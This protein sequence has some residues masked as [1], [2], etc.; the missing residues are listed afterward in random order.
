[1]AGR[2]FGVLRG[3]EISQITSAAGVAAGG[4]A[5]TNYTLLAAAVQGRRYAISFTVSG[6]SGTGDVGIAGATSLWD[7]SPVGSGGTIAGNGACT[8]VG[9]FIASGAINLYT[10]S[11][12]TANFSNISVKEVL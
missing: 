7:V 2:A 3:Q 9:T 4:P 12:N 11:T 1:M 10:R 8:Y 5:F 6:F